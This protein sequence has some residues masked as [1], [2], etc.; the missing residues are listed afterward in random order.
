MRYLIFCFFAIS[1][2]TSGYSQG[3]PS[4]VTPAE[5]RLQAVEQRKKMRDN[6]LVKHLPFTNIGPSVQS[7]RVVDMAIHPE[8]PTQFY[9][10]YASGGLWHTN[11]NGTTF[12][13]LFDQQDVMT[14]GAV[15]VDWK[16]NTIWV[17]TGEVNSSR[18]SY[19]GLGVYRS[20]DG[21]KSWQHRGLPESH[22]IG[23]I[24]IHP[25]NPNTVW[26]AVLGHLYS[27]NAERGIYKTTNGGE[28][29]EKTLFVNN[30]AGGIEMVID[31]MNP[32][33][34]YA[35]TWERTRRAWDFTEAG[36]GS[37]IYE[38]TDS[39]GSWSLISGPKSG[40]P[41]GEGAG[42][43]GLAMGYQGRTPILYA[44]IDNYNRRPKEADEEEGLTKDALRS[45]SKTD[46]AKLP[47]KQLQEYLRQNG[48]PKEYNTK[49]VQQM[50]A[51]GEIT[52]LTLVE[53]TESAN[54]LLFDTEVVGLEVYRMVNNSKKWSK[55]HD[56]YIDGVYYSYGYY[57]GVI[58][59]SPRDANRI[60]IMGV[61]V[62]RSDDGGTTWQGIN[63]ANVHS[64][65][66]ALWISPDRDGHIILGNDG[67]INI[68]YDDGENW[69]KCNHPP[70]GQF[71]YVAV[72]M[73]KP[74]K[75]YG[76]LQDNGVWM[77]DHTYEPSTRWQQSGQYPYEMI[78]GGD[79]MQVAVDTRDNA[80][81]YTGFQFGNYFRLNTKTKDRAY[82]TPKHDLGERPYR[83]NWQTPIHLSEHNAD[84]VYMGSNFVHRS[85]NQ[86]EDFTIISPDL[87]HGGQKGDVPYG[88][89]SAIHESPLRFGLLYAGSDDGRVHVSK[90]GGFQWEDISAGLPADMWV[91]RV[92]A[93]KYQEGRVY[94]SLNGY[95][96]DN[97]NAM[98]FRSDDYGKT[99]EIIGRDLPQEPINVVKEDPEVEGMIYVGTDHGAYLSLDNG[100]TFHAFLKG[101]AGAPVHDIVIHPRDKDI[102]IGTH[103]RS[104][105]R[106]SAR[107][108][109]ALTSEVLAEAVHLFKI[110]NQRRSRSWGRDSWSR[111]NVPSLNLPVFASQSGKAQVSI[112][113][114][115]GPV[116]HT[117]SVNLDKGLQ[118][119]TYDFTYGK[120]AW[121]AYRQY[122]EKNLEK[123]ESLPEMEP[124]DDGKYYLLP[125]KYK[126]IF[127]MNDQTSE[128]EFELK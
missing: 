103:G 68:S 20:T 49:K 85:L 80:T 77:G 3:V 13:P 7:G 114:E 119:A 75:V 59:V 17:G 107:E 76:G 72:D 34:L 74:Y 2:L 124:A 121:P 23:R 78:M 42:R 60:Y 1:I 79:G 100:A 38:S 118:Y 91:S 27:P 108:L 117:Y 81:V 120:D 37:G 35:A 31:P 89:L 116:L 58:K 61:P 32:E 48:F 83:W 47:E 97:W 94:L 22:H 112:Q 123:D 110:D 9:V 29:W 52:P 19:A 24:I 30:N 92:Q 56:D 50:I 28:S 10:A 106:A 62:I 15:A 70:L 109:Q 36:K 99:W 128:Q 64:D 41:S 63:G 39:G 87:T 11:N 14:L 44:S 18:S 73:A 127:K 25:T 5:Q 84:I 55:T 122:L 67:G 115:D 16:S 90:D 111:D 33:H 126:V 66:H 113:A 6:S 12:N 57:F 86:G 98:L 101:L 40:F 88:T 8:D 43:I 96:W 65:H 102:I 82:I 45:M 104:L 54:S 93:S 71:Y 95:R 125:G 46:F 53:Y 26:V 21:G 69:I 105:Y 51:D 4:L